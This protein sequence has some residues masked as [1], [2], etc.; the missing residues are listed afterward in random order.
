MQNP[1]IVKKKYPNSSFYKGMLYRNY[2]L[3]PTNNTVSAFD[4]K[5]SYISGDQFIPGDTF[6][7]LKNI[8]TKIKENKN[9][10]VVLK[11]IKT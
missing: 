2:S 1:E 11:T 9:G 10:I 5:N 6:I 8:K 3:V 7:L 4:I